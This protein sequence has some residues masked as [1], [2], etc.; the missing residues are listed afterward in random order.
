M[1]GSSSSREANQPGVDSIPAPGCHSRLAGARRLGTYRR[2]NRSRRRGGRNRGAL[3]RAARG[4]EQR[5]RF[6]LRVGYRER[7]GYNQHYRRRDQRNGHPRAGPELGVF[8]HAAGGGGGLRRR[9]AGRPGNLPTV[10]GRVED[11][12]ILARLPVVHWCI[13]WSGLYPGAGMMIKFYPTQAGYTQNCRSD[14]R[15]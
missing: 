14:V 15:Y 2:S 6:Q 9:R 13:R 8:H 10:H 7:F 1:W 5:D 11:L 12:F 3:E 4:R